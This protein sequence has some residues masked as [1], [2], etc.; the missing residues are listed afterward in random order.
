VTTGRYDFNVAPSVAWAI[1]KAI[2]DRSSRC[3][4]RAGTCPSTRSRTLLPGALEAF[5]K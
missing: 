2:P 4:R 3:S 5:L 1:H